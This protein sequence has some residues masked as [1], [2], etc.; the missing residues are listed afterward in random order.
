MSARHKTLAPRH[1][2]AFQQKYPSNWT[3][4]SL[5]EICQIVRGVIFKRDQSVNDYQ[6]DHI[7]VIRAGNIAREL[8]VTDDLVWIPKHLVSPDQMLRVHDI[9]MCTSSG[10]ASAVGKTAKLRTNWNGT[11]GGFC[12]IIR[13]PCKRL[14]DFLSFWFRSNRFLEWRDSQAQGSNIQNLKISDLGDLRLAL[15]S[16]AEQLRIVDTL[17]SQLLAID[18]ARTL[19]KAE[20][21]FALA[22]EAAL[23]RRSI[24]SVEA[25]LR[26]GWKRLSLSEVS[27]PIRGVTF[28]SGQASLSPKEDHTACITTSSV[29]EI[30]DWSEVRYIPNQCISSSRQI[31]RENDVIVSTANS[32]DL[33]GKSCLVTSIPAEATFGAF[34]TVLRP[35]NQNVIPQ[36]LLLAIRHDEAR[37]YFLDSSSHTTNISNLRVGDLLRYRIPIPPVAEQLRLSSELRNQLESAARIAVKCEQRFADL[38][39]M[40][41][42][43][44]NRAFEAEI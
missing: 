33:V 38:E 12:A 37:R 5:G 15:P 40:A 6:N 36:W 3:A 29:Q 32:K 14:S 39:A 21:N 27:K 34:V 1:R 31:L 43:V 4:L 13:A 7:A 22:L 20:L 35:T 2:P 24:P 41:A 25:D 28:K 23:I 18:E 30:I 10:S 16:E 19:V 8:L 9:V 42:A 17:S 11:L 44:I 26:Y